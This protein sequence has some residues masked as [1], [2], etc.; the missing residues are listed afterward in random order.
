[1]ALHQAEHAG[2]LAS[3]GR[4]AAGVAH[5]INNPLAIINEKAGLLL[6][7][8]TYGRECNQ[9]P[10]L[11]GLVDSIITAVERCGTITRRLLSFARHM[12]ASLA[13]VALPELV[14]EV[15]GFLGK[16]A[17]Y[18]S[19][20][21]N[22]TTNGEIPPFVSDRGKLQQIFLNL[23]NNAFAAMNDGGHLDITIGRESADT[24]AVTVADD[25]CGIPEADL[26]RIFEPFFTTKKSK[27]GTGLGLSITYG[28]VQ[29]LVAGWTSRAGWARARPSP[30]TCP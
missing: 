5:E 26:K 22:V 19:I 28:L 15:L 20:T 18:R 24:V 9:N 3:I 27:G 8:F 1:M 6:D 16:E 7:L 21:V 30:C 29:D 10:K 25:G 14:G 13:E 4:L 23:V 17:A 12:D 11:K 2:K